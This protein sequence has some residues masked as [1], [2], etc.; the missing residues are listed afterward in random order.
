M[1]GPPTQKVDPRAQ[2]IVDFGSWL[3]KEID[4]DWFLSSFMT[5]VLVV[6]LCTLGMIGHLPP[7]GALWGFLFCPIIATGLRIGALYYIERYKRVMNTMPFGRASEIVSIIWL[8]ITCALV[9]CS[10][11]LCFEPSLLLGI[12]IANTTFSALQAVHYSLIIDLVKKKLE[13]S[14]PGLTRNASFVIDMDNNK[15]PEHISLV[16][17]DK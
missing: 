6:V 15:P 7:T 11:I 16:S 10:I 12:L 2:K 13:V 3:W 17:E 8:A 1:P 14:I 9:L 4:F 5:P